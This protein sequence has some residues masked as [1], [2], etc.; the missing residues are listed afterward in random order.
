MPNN[1]KPVVI[2][3]GLLFPLMSLL[4]PLIRRVIPSAKQTMRPT[5]I[6]SGEKINKITNRAEPYKYIRNN[7]KAVNPVNKKPS[8]IQ[9]ASIFLILLLLFPSVTKS[10]PV[11]AR[12]AMTTTIMI[13]KTVKSF[14]VA[15]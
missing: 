15:D 5:I 11:T 13:T 1:T 12:A 2:L 8:T 3:D 7:S 4:K 10:V 9:P 14:V 6:M